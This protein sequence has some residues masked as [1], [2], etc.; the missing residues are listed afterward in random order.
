MMA[1]LH[2]GDDTGLLSPDLVS[3]LQDDWIDVLL[4]GHLE[5]DIH[6]GRM[7]HKE[8]GRDPADAT[9][10][11]EHQSLPW[12]SRDRRGTWNRFALTGNQ[13]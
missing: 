2:M 1:G 12:T 8:A 7:L 11:R 4:K 5:M 10:A 13:L 6:R 9:Q 3:S